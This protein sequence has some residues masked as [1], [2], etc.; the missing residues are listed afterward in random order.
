MMT[1]EE[2]VV[3]SKEEGFSPEVTGQREP[4]HTQALASWVAGSE[5]FWSESPGIA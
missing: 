4:S 2:T 3:M 1:Y 5:N